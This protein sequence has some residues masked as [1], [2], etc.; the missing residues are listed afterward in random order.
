[1]RRSFKIVKMDLTQHEKTVGN[2][3]HERSLYRAWTGAAVAR[4]WQHASS[5]YH[6]GLQLPTF[7]RFA[8]TK[9]RL[10]PRRI[11][12]FRNLGFGLVDSQLGYSH[13]D[14][15]WDDFHF[16]RKH[17]FRMFPGICWPSDVFIMSLCLFREDSCPNQS[18]VLGFLGLQE[19]DLQGCAKPPSS[20]SASCRL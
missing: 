5:S 15:C 16:Q 6:G 14:R 1:M 19:Y 13:A 18:F 12:I 9:H 4:F 7:K 11:H 2:H 10:V 17:G 3:G 8:S 20:L